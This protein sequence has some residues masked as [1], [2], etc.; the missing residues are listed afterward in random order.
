MNFELEIHS[1]F[2][3]NKNKKH[4]RKTDYEDDVGNIFSILE[5]DMADS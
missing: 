1:E 3:S 2:E 4:V 5:D